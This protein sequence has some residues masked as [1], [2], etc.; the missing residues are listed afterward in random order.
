MRDAGRALRGGH[1]SLHVVVDARLARE[2]REAL[3][4]HLF[5]L[6][7]GFPGVLEREDAPDIGECAGERRG[8]VEIAGDH[9]GAALRQ[10]AGGGGIGLAG[11][12]ADLEAVGQ[13][14]SRG[15]AALLAGRAGDE[16]QT[17]AGVHVA[18]LWIVWV[19]R[20]AVERMREF[21]SRASRHSSSRSHSAFSF[22]RPMPPNPSTS[23]A[24]TASLAFST[25]AR[26]SRVMPTRMARRSSSSRDFST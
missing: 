4:L 11:H 9:F 23:L 3:A 26:P 5:L 20:S 16:D 25:S 17:L 10:I 18:L 21:Q 24:R 22:F 12:R 2:F 6:D 1:R 7:A 13:E 15:R 14:F 19:V 8:V